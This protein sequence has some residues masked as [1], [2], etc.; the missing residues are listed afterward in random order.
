RDAELI[1]NTAR[2][3]KVV[4]RAAAAL[5]RGTAFPQTHRDADDVVSGLD[6][7][8]SCQGAVDAA[9]HGD[10]NP[11]ARKAFSRLTKLHHRSRTM[12]PEARQL[13]QYAMSIRCCAADCSV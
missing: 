13:T 9:A 11:F 7:Q 5:D 2:I 3:E 4:E 10:H 1:G 6:Q 8:R 12:R